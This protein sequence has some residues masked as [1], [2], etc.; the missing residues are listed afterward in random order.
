MIQG[1]IAGMKTYVERNIETEIVRYLTA[2]EVIA[3]VGVRQCGKTTLMRKLASSLE[4]DN[5]VNF[6]SFDNISVL[7]LFEEDVESFIE[8][9]VKA[10]DYLFIDEIQYSRQSGRTLKYIYDNYDVKM[11]ISGSSAAEISIQSIKYLVGRIFIFTLYPFSFNEFLR[12]RAPNMIPVYEKGNYKKEITRQLNRYLNEFLLYGGFPRVVTAKETEEKKTV[13]QNIYNT[14]LLR[15]LKEIFQLAD[16]LKLIKLLK[17]LALQ[18]GDLVNFNEISNQSGIKLPELKNIAAILESTFV[19]SFIQ[20]F[21]TNKRTELVKASKTYFVDPGFRNVCIGHFSEVEL[22]E[23]R[24][25]E[26]FVFTEF[27][28]RNIKLKYWRSKSQA[29]VDFVYEKEGKIVPVEI[30]SSLKAPKVS[31]SMHSFLTKY[32]TQGAFILTEDFEQRSELKSGKQVQFL[33]WIKF[34]QI[35]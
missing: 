2:K 28:K 9:H 25:R 4:D 31:R 18:T 27:Q 20:P 17:L 22:M 12:F 26:Q 13:L 5:K 32:E 16:S 15:E 34:K 30:K 21:Y 1:R 7:Q 23:G 3:I 33:P 11:I 24:A 14:Y 8:L 6:I 35:M 19:V 29:E 10:Y